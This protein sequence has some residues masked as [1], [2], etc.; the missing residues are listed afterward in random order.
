MSISQDNEPTKGSRPCEPMQL[1][2]WA[3]TNNR[4]RFLS[5]DKKSASQIRREIF[6]HQKNSDTQKSPLC[7]LWCWHGYLGWGAYLHM[8]QQMPLPLTISCSSK[9]RLA[10][11][12]WFY[13]SRTCS[14]GWSRTNSRRA[15]YLREPCYVSKWR[16]RLHSVYLTSSFNDVIFSTAN[17]L[18]LVTSKSPG[19]E[20]S[21]VSV[22]V[23]LIVSELM[24]FFIKLRFHCTFLITRSLQLLLP[25]S[26]VLANI[27]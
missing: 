15:C 1:E 4:I 18:W 26:H 6:L 22:K 10:L 25:A 8:A 16:H 2:S 11:P 5:T 3:S 12:S 9:S 7:E 13:L 27:Q 17:C 20:V 24:S 23:G 21:T 19:I 14:P